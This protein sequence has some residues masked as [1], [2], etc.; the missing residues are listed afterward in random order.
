MLN[1]A[2]SHHALNERN[3]CEHAHKTSHLLTRLDTTWTSAL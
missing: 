1:R 3:P 2:H